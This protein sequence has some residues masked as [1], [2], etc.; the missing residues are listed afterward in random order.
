MAALSWKSWNFPVCVLS[1]RIV[2]VVVSRLVKSQSARSKKGVKHLQGTPFGE[3]GPAAILKEQRKERE[4]HEDLSTTKYRQFS[5]LCLTGH[6]RQ[7]FEARGSYR[8]SS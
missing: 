2:V 3:L 7:R 8:Q 6:I 5:W 4:Q 1:K